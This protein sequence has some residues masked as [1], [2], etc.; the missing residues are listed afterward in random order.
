MSFA[1]VRLYNAVQPSFSAKK[2]G[3]IDAG[4]NLNGVDHINHDAVNNAIFDVNEDE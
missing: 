4:I 1:N 3:I 2:D